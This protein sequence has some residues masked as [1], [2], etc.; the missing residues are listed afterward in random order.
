[1]KYLQ[2]VVSLFETAYIL[3]FPGGIP[4]LKKKL[5]P[6]LGETSEFWGKLVIFLL[7]SVNVGSSSLVNGG[8]MIFYFYLQ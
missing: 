4:W 5:R 7:P 6:V 8:A 1:M 3:P 2:V